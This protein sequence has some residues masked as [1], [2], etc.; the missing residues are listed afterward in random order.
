LYFDLSDTWNA[1][2]RIVTNHFLAF[3]G[4]IGGVFEILIFLSGILLYPLAE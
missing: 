2:N 4:A 3:L 1:H